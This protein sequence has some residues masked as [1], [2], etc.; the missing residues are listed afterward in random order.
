MSFN[1]HNRICHAER[2][3]VIRPLRGLITL[4]ISVPSEPDTS[5]SLPLSEAKGSG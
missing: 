5:R 2:S 3:S 1:D 4:S